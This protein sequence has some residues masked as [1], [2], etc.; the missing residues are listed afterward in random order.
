MIS[1]F[2][3]FDAFSRRVYDE[4]SKLNSGTFF[5]MTFCTSGGAGLLSGIFLFFVTFCAQLVHDIFLF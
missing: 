3:D 4:K 1:Q 2:P 5:N